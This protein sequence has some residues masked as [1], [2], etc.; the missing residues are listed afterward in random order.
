MEFEYLRLKD[1]LPGISNVF[2]LQ[3]YT[4]A[5]VA[6]LIQI[7]DGSVISAQ[8]A[9]IKHAGLWVHNLRQARQFM[10]SQSIVCIILYSFLLKFFQTCINPS[11]LGKCSLNRIYYIVFCLPSEQIQTP[12]NSPAIPGGCGTM[13][14][15]ASAPTFRRASEA[16]HSRPSVGQAS[17]SGCRMVGVRPGK[18]WALS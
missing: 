18:I 13:F 6:I 16:N 11:V 8:P 10:W 17:Y 4:V 7:Q 1:L 12:H 3:I 15:T 5:G 14:P 9:S 2:V